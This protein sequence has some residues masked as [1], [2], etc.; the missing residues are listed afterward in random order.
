MPFANN[1]EAKESKRDRYKWRWDNEPGFAEKERE[2]A[3]KNYE[4]N[5]ERIIAR[6]IARR[7]KR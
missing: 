2:R 4:L 7:E 3:R 1:E 5:R 6:V